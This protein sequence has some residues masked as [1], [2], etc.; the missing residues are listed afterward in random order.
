[1]LSVVLYTRVNKLPLDCIGCE[2][3]KALALPV[4]FSISSVQEENLY[5]SFQGINMYTCDFAW[6][7]SLTETFSICTMEVSLEELK[8]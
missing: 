8:Q 4:A 2:S 3:N 5:P 6:M 1:M 7:S